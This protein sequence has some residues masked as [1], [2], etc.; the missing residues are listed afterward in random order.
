MI[1]REAADSDIPIDLKTQDPRFNLTSV[2]RNT[3]LSTIQ[4]SGRTQG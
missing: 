2:S 1:G 4:A 3:R